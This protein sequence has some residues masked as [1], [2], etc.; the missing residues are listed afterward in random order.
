MPVSG[1]RETTPKRASKS[2]F[3]LNSIAARYVDLLSAVAGCCERLVTAD[4]A[5]A[6]RRVR[7]VR[8]TGSLL[9]MS[10]IA[11]SAVALVAASTLG[12]AGVLAAVSAILAIFWLGALL[13]AG[14]K[15]ERLVPAA[16]LAA[17]AT[18][19]PALIALAGGIGSPLALLLAALVVEPLWADRT[20]AGRVGAGVA[21]SVAILGLAMI[22]AEASIGGSA[23]A[24][25][26]IPGLAYL[27]FV[28]ARLAPTKGQTVSAG[29]IDKTLLDASGA[30][31]LR[32]STAGDVISAMGR[33]RDVLGVPAEILLGGGLFER[34]RVSDRVG[35]LCALG[36]AQGGASARRVS[37]LVRVPAGNDADAS[38]HHLF[39]FDFA[40]ASDGSGEVFAIA[41]RNIEVERLTAELVE[42]E[43]R[44]DAMDMVRS[45]LLASVSHEL[46]TP[47]NAIIGFSDMLLLELFGKFGDPRQREYVTLVRDSGHHL[48]EVVNSILDVSKIESGAYS[49]VPEPFVLADAVEMCRSMMDGQAQ[50]K[51]VRL[52]VSKTADMGEIVADR[53]AVQQMLINLVSNAIKFTPAGGA[54]SIQA[55]KSGPFVKLAVIDN[56]IG[57]AEQDLARI[58]EPFTQVHNDYTRQFDGAGLGLSLVKGLVS[59]HGGSMAIESAPGQGTTVTITL[60]IDGPASR[61]EAEGKVILLGKS[62]SRSASDGSLRKTA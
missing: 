6:E 30:L 28:A 19:L 14:G 21:L 34:M 56:G 24:L 42:A 22:P 1:Q 27:A 10:F 39:D 2:A 18:G 61:K 41:R 62:G 49:I 50:A 40:A 11:S 16:V 58:G 60:P 44:R 45:R 31:V 12:V 13:V 52:S 54:V 57:I 36:D 37:A 38:S 7:L 51:P 5:S 59:L 25:N 26:W 15:A 48:L 32:L 17:C 55:S 23:P 9:G 47:L 20:R 43:R 53:R 29:T 3:E 33:T 35:F 4:A 8:A 46:R